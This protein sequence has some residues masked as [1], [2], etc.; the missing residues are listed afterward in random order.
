M[1]DIRNLAS[2]RLYRTII[3]EVELDIIWEPRPQPEAFIRWKWSS[4]SQQNSKARGSVVF[5]TTARL[6]NITCRPTAKKP[7]VA[8][9]SSQLVA[10]VFRDATPESTKVAGKVIFFAVGVFTWRAGSLISIIWKHAQRKRR[11]AQRLNCAMFSVDSI[12]FTSDKGR[13]VYRLQAKLLPLRAAIVC[14]VWKDRNRSLAW[15]KRQSFRQATTCCT[16][17]SR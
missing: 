3:Y 14:Y 9:A 11:T 10:K 6:A 12:C 4:R 2:P 1:W 15:F 16:E 8:E 5:V 17:S 13:H 7:W